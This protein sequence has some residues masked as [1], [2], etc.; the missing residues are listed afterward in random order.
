LGGDHIW[1]V[2]IAH[3]A[4]AGGFAVYPVIFVILYLVSL[5]SLN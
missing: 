1:G 4:F 3:G 5:H 2:W